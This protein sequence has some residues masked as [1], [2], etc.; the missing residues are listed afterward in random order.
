MLVEG[1][2]NF[3]YLGRPL[4][5]TYNEWLAVIWNVNRLQRVWGEVREYSK[6]GRGEPQSGRNILQG[7]DTGGD[8]ICIGDLVPIGGNGKNGGRD[9]HHISKTNHGK[10][11]VLEGV[12][13]MVYYSDRGSA[14][15]GGNE[16][17][18][19]LHR[20]KKREGVPVGGTSEDI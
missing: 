15:S 14:G 4:E 17:G 18:H 20:K 9:S 3:K 8:T 16:V 11:G 6:K 5:Q 13:D 1:V 10:A 2:E 12:R 7:G 19:N